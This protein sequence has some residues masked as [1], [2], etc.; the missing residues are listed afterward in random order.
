MDKTK[1]K[2]ETYLQ[3]K[4]DYFKTKKSHAKSVHELRLYS[5]KVTEFVLHLQENVL[6]IIH[7]C[8]VTQE[9]EINELIGSL[10]DSTPLLHLASTVSQ[11]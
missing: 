11:N 2:V 3:E 10:K 7:D 6:K 8:G 4:H 1:L 5:N 9:K